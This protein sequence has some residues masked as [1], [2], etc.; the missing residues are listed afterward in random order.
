MPEILKV[1]KRLEIPDNA[2]KEDRR[3]T[4]RVALLSVF[5]YAMRPRGA[6]PWTVDLV[7]FRQQ[8]LPWEKGTT[9]YARAETFAANPLLAMCKYIDNPTYGY[10][11]VAHTPPES[12]SQQL[13]HVEAEIF[14]GLPIF[15]AKLPA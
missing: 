4:G 6:K 7:P 9:S 5:A 3:F 2:F 13:I 1:T 15:V 10:S 14:G 12:L 8:Q 11:I